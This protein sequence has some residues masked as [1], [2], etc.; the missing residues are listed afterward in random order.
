MAGAGRL[1]EL[2][3]NHEFRGPSLT[4]TPQELEQ[5]RELGLTWAKWPSTLGAD[6]DAPDSKPSQFDTRRACEQAR[7]AGLRPIIDLR[8]ST[9][10][11]EGLAMLAQFAYFDAGELSGD[12]DED[13]RLSNEDAQRAFLEEVSF[14]IDLH[15]QWCADWEFWGEWGCPWTSRGKFENPITYPGLL[16]AVSRTIKETQPEARV[17]L[18][19][20][21]MDLNPA[22]ILLALEHGAGEA[23]DVAN[24]HPYFMEIRDLEVA[25]ELMEKGFTEARTAL[26]VQ[27]KNQPFASSEWGYPTHDPDVPEP[28]LTYL[29]SNVAKGGIAQLSC[30][31]AVAWYEQDLT[32]MEQHGFET[33]C[34]HGLRDRMTAGKH[35]GNFCGLLTEDWRQKPTWEVVQQW[36][37]KGR[38]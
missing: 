17:W 34:V 2:G 13:M 18:G 24:W 8:T 5:Y 29:A 27:G 32:L 6:I 38:S 9:D 3:I 23:F 7:A 28:V 19:G 11:L 10:Q 30:A 14:I 4:I 37:W 35:W 33:V 16:K 22:H 26:R 1:M 12:L 36:A 31:E 25:R 20:Y 21:G 15:R